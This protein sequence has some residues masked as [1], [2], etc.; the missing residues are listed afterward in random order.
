MGFVQLSR[1]SDCN[2]LAYSLETHYLG[3]TIRVNPMNAGLV[4][5]VSD[6]FR[7]VYWPR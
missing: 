3:I 1:N 7:S 5:A 2:G 4:S 6:S